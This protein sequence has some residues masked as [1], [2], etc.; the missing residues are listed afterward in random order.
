MT[1]SVRPHGDRPLVDPETGETAPLS[2]A[3]RLSV[4]QAYERARSITLDQF[5]DAAMLTPK[6]RRTYIEGSWDTTEPDDA[7]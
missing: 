4:I 6:L 7:A 5:F 1:K 3:K 2:P